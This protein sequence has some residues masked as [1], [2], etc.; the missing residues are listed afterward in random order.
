[1]D[2]IAFASQYSVN[3]IGDISANLTHPQSIRA[4]CYASDLHFPRR[5]INEEQD[6]EALQ[7]S[8]GPDLHGEEI[9]SY[10]QFPV[11]CQKL[12]PSCFPAPL[13]RRFNPVAAENISDCAAG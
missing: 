4:R 10:D 11:S 6:E 5:Q 9:R 3:R 8:G 12:L 1:M 7:P 2:Q 13:R